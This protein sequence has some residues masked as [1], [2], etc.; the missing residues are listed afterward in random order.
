MTTDLYNRVLTLERT[1]AEDPDIGKRYEA[2]ETV[3]NMVMPI[4][5]GPFAVE[6][7]AEAGLNDE[8]HWLRLPI[9]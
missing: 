2:M 5:M 3:A 6:E 9:R 7:E 1:A 4:H 8:Y